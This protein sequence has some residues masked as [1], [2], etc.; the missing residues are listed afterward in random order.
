MGQVNDGKEET[1]MKVRIVIP[2]GGVD[3]EV[4]SIEAFCKSIKGSEWLRV[5]EGVVRVSQI[6]AVV[7]VEEKPEIAEVNNGD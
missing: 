5:G 3:A 7:P 4:E 1:K 2:G 6:I